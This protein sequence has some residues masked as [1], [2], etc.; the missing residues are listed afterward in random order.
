MQ[1]LRSNAEKYGINPKKI[2]AI[3]GS[4]GGHLAAMLAFLNEDDGLDPADSPY[5][6]VS[7]RVQAAVPMYGA[8]DLLAVAERRQMLDTLTEEEKKLCR[9]ASS[10]SYLEKRDPPTLILHG[11]KDHL[12]P[13]RQS[14]ILH[15]ALKKAGL[16]SQLHI[17]EG[18]PH[19]FHLQ[20]KQEDLRELVIGFFEKNLN[21]PNSQK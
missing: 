21:R 1:F 14:E 5:P 8:H 4:A 2:G 15:K 20:P 12:V 17:I 9:Q 10:I 3:G 6:D 11:T 19:S 7:C 13:V 16:P 18:A